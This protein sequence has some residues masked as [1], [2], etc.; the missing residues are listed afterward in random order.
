MT[1]WVFGK[2]PA[3]GDFVARGMD[4]ATRGAL[5][6]WLADALATARARFPGD[7]DARFDV[8]QPWRATGE[9]VAGAVAASQDA[10][11]RRFPVLLLADD[12]QLDPSACEDLLYAAI[13]EGWDVD[14]LAAAGSA[15][16]GVVARW[17][18]AQG[19]GLDGPHPV[20]LIVEMLA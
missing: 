13:T 2:L 7:F 10:V 6:D 9:G 4:A 14:R 19:N 16:R 17:S 12:A 20:E 15:P 5:D 1:A 18:S 11:G 3:H 8:A